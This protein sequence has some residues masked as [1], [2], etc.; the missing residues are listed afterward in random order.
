[1]KNFFLQGFHK[2]LILYP[3]KRLLCHQGVKAINFI[4]L[5]V[6][7]NPICIT[8]EAEATS[9]LQKI[10]RYCRF[11]H[12]IRM[13]VFPLRIDF[14]L[15]CTIQFSECQSTMNYYRR[16]RRRNFFDDSDI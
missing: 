9:D 1:M 4:S 14:R 7:K 12:W 16:M 6:L 15:L 5:T 3:P 2:I 11:C 13:G 8:F 10:K